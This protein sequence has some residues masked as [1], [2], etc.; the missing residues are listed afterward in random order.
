[1]TFGHRTFASV[2]RHR[3]YRLYFAGQA[4]SFTGTWV[5]QI[6]AS[7]LVLELTHSPVA[8]GA[9]ALAQL[10]PVTVLGLFVGSLLD[11]YEVRR[12]ALATESAQL[13][14][15]GVLAILTLGGWVHVWQ[16]FALAVLQ[17][18]AQSIGGPARHALVFQMV[19]PEDLPNAIGLNS[20]LGTT[21]RVVGPAIGGGIVAVAGSGVAFAINSGSFFAELLALV[22]IDITKLYVAPRDGTA[23]VLGGAIAALR[24][25][26]GSARAGIAFFGVLILSTLSFNLNVLFPLLADRTLRS[27]AQTFGLIAA[28]FGLGALVGALASARRGANS[29]RYFLIGAFGYG[30]LELVLAPQTSLP[31]VCG[32]LVAIGFFYIQWGAT[33]LTAI[34]LEAPEY[35]RGRA[36][37]LYFWAFLGGAPVGGVFAGWLVSVGGTR[38]AFFVAGSVAVVT[39]IVGGLRLVTSGENRRSAVAHAASGR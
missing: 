36:A 21:A 26:V 3:N 6:A 39:S 12:V 31:L 38:L 11:R 29:L 18:I 33:A 8:V 10:L 7:W 15:S 20:S 27:G 34:Q 22:A 35:L 9:L 17:G 16:I 2:R 24:Y 13:A 4:I 23:S 14:I 25:V 28:M 32:L 1:M 30:V 5:Q 19:G 37:S